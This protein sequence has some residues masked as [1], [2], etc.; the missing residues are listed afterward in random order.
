MIEVLTTSALWFGPSERPLFGRAYLPEGGTAYAGVVLCPPFG[1]EAQGAGR[2]YRALGQRLAAEGFAVLQVDYDG[3]GDSAGWASDPGRA[4]AWQ[5][6]VRA[7]VDVLR[8]GGAGKVC[9]VGMRLGATVAAAASAGC[10]LDGLVLWDPCDSGRS[11]LREEALLRSVYLGDQGLDIPPEQTGPAAGSAETLGTVYDAATVHAMTR[12]TLES[13][14]GPLARHVLALLR[15]ERPP[16]RAVKQWLSEVGAEPG[17]AAGQEQ[18]IS[19]WPLK[20]VVPQ[21]TLDIIVSWLAGVAAGEKSTVLLPTSPTAVVPGPDGQEVCEEI[22]YLG[23]GRLFG[24]LTRPAGPN[25]PGPRGPR[26]GGGASPAGPGVVPGGGAS[27]GSSR[28]GGTGP[29]GG[30]GPNGPSP[31]TTVVML[32]SGRIDHVG[33]GRLWVDLA[34]S[35]AACGLEVLRVDLSGLGDSPPR[36]GCAPDVVYSPHAI[37]DVAQVARAVSPRD[38][39]AVV[40]MGLCSGA[41]HSVEAALATGARGVVAIN[42]VPPS[43]PEP[44]APGTTASGT[45]APGTT[46][47]GT[48]GPASR[49]TGYRARLGETLAVLH[50]AGSHLPGHHY[51]GALSRRASDVKW[52]VVHRA[53]GG[54]VPAFDL[55]LL[56]RKG[57]D[58]LVVAGSYEA[59]LVQQGEGPM[60]W[61]LQKRGGLR[62]AVLPTIDHTLFTQAARRQVVPLVT[63]RVRA[64]CATLPAS[65]GA[66][67]PG[68]AASG[69][70][71]GPAAP[72]ARPDFASTP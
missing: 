14:P 42:L 72:G 32:N 53:R 19:V 65:P 58:T 11:Y 55:R 35:W 70:S 57:V 15:P 30:T 7:A 21:A 50:R 47:S 10:A 22:R 12:L 46:A 37:D 60:L 43:P 26:P 52:W 34:R 9:V 38:P 66:P 39:A 6:S 56:A 64:Q 28:P 59:R 8:A 27:P 4:Q 23:P 29:S 5:A 45:T 17:E 63:E 51:L 61:R 18:L 41:Y 54:A 25:R 36:P 31:G 62:V 13:C 16:R 48:T 3:T 49:A 24:V 67:K 2:A 68:P 1:L 33:P 71:P 20:S 69:A 40:L 44:P